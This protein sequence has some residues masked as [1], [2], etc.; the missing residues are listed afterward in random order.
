MSSAS[1]YRHNAFVSIRKRR[2]KKST[3]KK[4]FDSPNKRTLKESMSG[5]WFEQE[6]LLS[7]SSI[8]VDNEPAS[9]SSQK[10]LVDWQSEDESSS[11]ESDESDEEM[12]EE[13]MPVT[14]WIIDIQLLDMYLQEVAKCKKCSHSLSIKEQLSCRAGTKLIFE[15]TNSRRSSLHTYKGFFT[16]KK[17]GATYDINRKSVLAS[18]A[19]GKG[20]SGLEKLCSIINLYPITRK[21]FTEHTKFWETHVTKL[22]RENV[23]AA[24]KRAKKIFIEENSLSKDTQIVDLPTCF[25]GSWSTRGWVARKG[26]VAAIAENSSQVIDI[27]F[28]SN[29]CRYCEILLEKRKNCVI[30]ELEYLTLYTQ[31]EPECFHNHDGSPRYVGFVNL[32]FAYFAFTVN[33]F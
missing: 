26:I 15:C 33:F 7:Y 20:Y 31:H 13:S 10:K 1:K 16:S 22:M 12:F 25:D 6:K 21:A 17:S 8:A 28:K 2:K 14:D 29:Y 5:S 23:A 11:D 18:R 30:D 9:S 19:I 24:A 32:S 27:V 3:E 4:L